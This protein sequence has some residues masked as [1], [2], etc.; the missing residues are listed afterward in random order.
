[1]SKSQIEVTQF[2][3]DVE[4]VKIELFNQDGILVNAVRKVLL[5]AIYNNG[6][7]RKDIPP[8]PMRNAA[9]SL[10]IATANGQN[11]ISNENLGEDIRGMAQAVLLLEQGL[12]QLQKITSKKAEPEET[13]GNPAI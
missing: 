2:L 1:M 10:A 4:K 7:L 5:E 6:V 9:L 11:M 12:A 3:S 8:E 13:S